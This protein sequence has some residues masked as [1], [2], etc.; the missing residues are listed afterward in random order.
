MQKVIQDH[1][2][3]T[4][5]FSLT[6]INCQRQLLCKIITF[7]SIFSSLQLKYHIFGLETYLW[8][9]LQQQ[10]MKQHLNIFIY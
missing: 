1:K 10:L 2:V 9:D 5:D 6:Q 7:L 3:P 8:V 4:N